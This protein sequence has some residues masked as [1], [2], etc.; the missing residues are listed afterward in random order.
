[1]NDT[2]SLCILWQEKTAIRFHVKAFARFSVSSSFQFHLELQGWQPVPRFRS[3]YS[4]RHTQNG[5]RVIRSECFP[6]AISNML[7]NL[8]NSVWRYQM[9][10]N[11]CLEEYSTGS[12]SSFQL[13]LEEK[14]LWSDWHFVNFQGT[15]QGT[16]GSAGVFLWHDIHSPG[17]FPRIDRVIEKINV[18]LNCWQGFTLLHSNPWITW[19]G[20]EWRP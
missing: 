3:W 14:R 9:T 13:H 16:L 17:Q 5:A 2:L 18:C 19:A 20:A 7:F 1:M 11:E 8:L 12:L 10:L 15:F 4:S 6:R